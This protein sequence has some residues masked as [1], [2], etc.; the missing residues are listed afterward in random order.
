MS[1]F[2]SRW[3]LPGS[4][5]SATIQ[6][7]AGRSSQARS[8]PSQ[9][10]SPKLSRKDCAKFGRR[11]AEKVASSRPKQNCEGKKDSN[12]LLHKIAKPQAPNDTGRLKTITQINTSALVSNDK[13]V[14]LS[15]LSLGRGTHQLTL[16]D[17]N[18]ERENGRLRN[19][20]AQ[21]KDTEDRK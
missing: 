8:R 7:A 13:G 19:V 6:Q 4:G 21:P 15:L 16:E 9:R 17:P 1:A 5:A 20:T 11:V 2:S 14:C 10:C 18:V 3:A 12:P